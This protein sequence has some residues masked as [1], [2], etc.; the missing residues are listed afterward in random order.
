MNIVIL[1][2]KLFR[3]YIYKK[4]VAYKKKWFETNIIADKGKI[5]LLYFYYHTKIP[6]ILN[7]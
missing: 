6:C 1:F 7:F 4:N 2:L 3:V 5:Y